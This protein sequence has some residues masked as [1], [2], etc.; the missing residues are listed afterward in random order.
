MKSDGQAYK[1]ATD[2][3]VFQ[4]GSWKAHY[5]LVICT[6]TYIVNYMD[7]VVLTV[8]LQPLKIELSLSDLQL[9]SIQMAY[10]LSHCFSVMPIAFAVDRWSRTKA[11]GILVIVWSAFT[12]FT[13]V[14]WNFAALI[15]ARIFTGVG[16]TGLAAGGV[17]L[18]TAAYPRE[19]QGWAMGIY[20]AGLP[21][22]L[23]VGA[24]IGGIM[25]ATLGWRSP[26]LLL[27]LFGLILAI[28]A[29]F[30]YDYPSINE[31]IAGGF[32]GFRQA[33]S[34]LL[35]IPTLRWFL[36]GYGLLMITSQA[37][38]IWL[39]AFLI[40]KFQVGTDYAGYAMC[41]VCLLAVIGAA[42]GGL[43]A[44]RWYR[45]DRRG[46]LWL[47]ALASLLS[48]IFLALS[49]ISFNLGFWP[50]IASSILFGIINMT[51][52]P[53]LTIVSQDIVPPAHKGLSYGLTVLCMYLLG[54]AWSPVIVGGISDSLGGG[55]DGLMWAVII[56][57]TGGLLACLCF[58]ISGR[59]YLDDHILATQ[60]P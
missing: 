33:V 56:A 40:R 7:R 31:G 36:L 4:P 57:S 48:S 6:L 16:A 43:L 58:F 54:G 55:A 25:A 37:Q 39:P 13:G 28:A 26:F 22:G 50:G 11:V 3:K 38:M 5:L 15:S 27:G 42:A 14:A 35:R 34:T 17:S 41:G 8:I 18:I 19:K 59:H 46:R 53:S 49:F 29:F 24:V 44:D 51:A 45:H 2:N 9:G 21:L 47:P 20:H 10:L 52:I 60:A 30:M 32:H 12:A 1:T 23:A